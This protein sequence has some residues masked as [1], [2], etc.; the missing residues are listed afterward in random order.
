MDIKT[1]LIINVLLSTFMCLIFFLYWRQK[2]AHA[3]F[4]FW[5]AAIGTTLL[6]YTALVSRV[7]VPVG[8]S[9][10][11]AD[12]LLV[13]SA[14]FRLDAT[15]LFTRNRRIPK[16]AYLIPFIVAVVCT[17]FYYIIDNVAVR[18]GVTSFP[19]AI[20]LLFMAYFF[21]RYESK[22]NRATYNIMATL[23][24]LLSI[25]IIMEMINLFVISP[26]EYFTSN[27]FRSY[28]F[29][30]LILYEIG[31]DNLFIILNMQR[32]EQ[33]LSDT[34]E[35]LKDSEN[36]HRILS[37]ASFEGLAIMD[38]GVV[39]EGNTKI[40]EIFGYEMD[41]IIGISANKFI[42][43]SAKEDVTQKIREG[44]ELPYEST[45]L[46]KDGTE[47]PVEFQGK[48]FNYHGHPARITAVRD[49]T[50]QKKAEDEVKKLKGILPICS[51]CNKIRD[52]KGEWSEVDVY[53]NDNSEADVSHSV[54][55]TCT[56]EHY[57][58]YIE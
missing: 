28:F 43:E 8:P 46:K 38:K 10:I 52:S 44:Y 6:G 57:S 47:F 12:F 7:V 50:L 17:F 21:V 31:S 36:R 55:P 27:S 3:G 29:L 14:L 42:A 32:S 5:T 49:L 40:C 4:G 18:N 2:R 41:E 54:C 1:E 11:A 58:K 51:F 25:A 33:Q 35:A 9:I 15:S 34:T 16:Q 19:I 30:L 23:N 56:K 48:M 13:I 53:I 26:S 45:G 24:V 37:E 20:T 22:T 39:I